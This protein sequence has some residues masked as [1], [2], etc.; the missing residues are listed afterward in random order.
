MFEHRVY[1][2]AMYNVTA[3]AASLKT[4]DIILLKDK[5]LTY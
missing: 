1:S 4:E 3:R 2:L 5:I